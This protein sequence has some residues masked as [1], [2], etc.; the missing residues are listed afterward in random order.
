[1]TGITGKL[2]VC[3]LLRKK[4]Y[5]IIYMGNSIVTDVTISETYSPAAAKFINTDPWVYLSE[6]LAPYIL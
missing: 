6:T 2:I 4:N 1:M 5:M 3:S